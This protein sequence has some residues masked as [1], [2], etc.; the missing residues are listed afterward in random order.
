MFLSE[1][2]GADEHR[3]EI[4]Q[5]AECGQPG[6]PEIECHRMTSNV[7]AQVNIG[8]WQAHQS[9]HDCDPKQIVHG[10][11][12]LER[13]CQRDNGCTV[14]DGPDAVLTFAE[15]RLEIG[16]SRATDIG[17]DVGNAECQVVPAGV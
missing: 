4:S 10:S 15:A 14:C 8:E 6:E 5:K 9:E 2:F 17:V 12:P 1:A 3:H 13:R 7:I 11:S 16:C